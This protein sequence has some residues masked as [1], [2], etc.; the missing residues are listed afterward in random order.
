MVYVIKSLFMT[1]ENKNIWERPEV[2]ELGDAK[3]IIKGFA[4][5][6]PKVS[7]GGD[8]DLDVASDL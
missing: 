8:S 5:S 4:P 3:E 7:G 6:D 1:A 2:K